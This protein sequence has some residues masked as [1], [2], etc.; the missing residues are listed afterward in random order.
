MVAGHLPAETSRQA[1]DH[2]TGRERLR[3]G[4]VL[5][6]SIQVAGSGPP[7]T[8]AISKPPGVALFD[9]KDALY[10]SAG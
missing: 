10:L 8:T 6:E 9:A 3:R 5:D 2:V 7:E 1:H 4:S